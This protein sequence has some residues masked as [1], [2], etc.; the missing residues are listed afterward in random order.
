MNNHYHFFMTWDHWRMVQTLE[1]FQKQIVSK[2]M[3]TCHSMRK[4]HAKSKDYFLLKKDCCHIQISF[5][6]KFGIVSG[7]PTRYKKSS[8]DEPGAFSEKSLFQIFQ[9]FFPKLGSCHKQGLF[10][11]KICLGI[12]Q[13]ANLFQKN[14]QFHYWKG[15]PY[16]ERSFQTGFFSKAKNFLYFF[17]NYFNNVLTFE[18]YLLS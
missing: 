16:K 9:E 18:I 14:V 1:I 12:F 7:I 5:Q 10:L 2:I 3:K 8:S 17:W 13:E 11:M 15:S 4:F 6:K